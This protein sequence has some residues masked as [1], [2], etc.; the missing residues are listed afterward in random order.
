M[1]VS[2]LARAI[3]LVPNWRD[4]TDAEL[5]DALTGITREPITL[6]ADR[7]WSIAGISR[8]YSIQFGEAIYQGLVSAGLA[9]VAARFASTGLDAAD[10]QWTQMAEAL[11]PGLVAAG[12]DDATIDQVK[13]LGY[14]SYTLWED[15]LTEAEAAA[16][17]QELLDAYRLTNAIALFAERMTVDG[18]A[19]AVWNQAWADAEA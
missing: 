2:S 13:W 11:R 8:D 15:P 9:G 1:N 18:N 4:L 17:R 16:G 10:P 14:K 6:E 12:F 19:A 3:E 7:M 5:L